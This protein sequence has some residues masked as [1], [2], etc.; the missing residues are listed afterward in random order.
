[1][2]MVA[3]QQILLLAA[4][5]IPR[6][7]APHPGSQPR[8]VTDNLNDILSTVRG[9]RGS[10]QL[11]STL[12]KSVVTSVLFSTH[13]I[14]FDDTRSAHTAFRKAVLALKNRHSDVPFATRIAEKKRLLMLYRSAVFSRAK[15]VALAGFP[16]GTIQSVWIMS[17]SRSSLKM[18]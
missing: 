18:K 15:Q 1:A 11:I 17:R 6:G 9:Q 12:I 2:E 13:G 14:H 5:G 7:H 4:Q 8:S 10:S 16:E 3:R